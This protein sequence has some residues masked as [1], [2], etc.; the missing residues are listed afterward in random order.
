MLVTFQLP[1][2]DSAMNRFPERILAK[3]GREKAAGNTQ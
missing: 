1:G 3:N 2:R